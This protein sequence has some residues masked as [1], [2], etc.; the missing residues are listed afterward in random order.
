MATL[1]IETPPVIE[2][3]SL[4]DM[5]RWLREEQDF[6]DNDAQI[7]GLITAARELVEGFTGRSLVTKGYRQCLD[8]FPYYVDTVMSQMAYPPSYYS[9]PRWSTTLWNYSQMI[10]LFVAPLVTVDRIT[11]RSFKDSQWHSLV[12]SVQLWMPGVKYASG[13][14]VRDGNGNLQTAGADG[15][16]GDNPPVWAANLGD[17]TTDNSIPWTNGGASPDDGF[18]MDFDS[19]PP[20]LFP[21]P[22]AGGPTIAFWPSVLYVP[23]AVQIHFTAGY[24]ST[25]AAILASGRQGMV[26][27]IQQLVG[28][29]Y[30]HREAVSPLHM[31]ELPN[32]IKALLWNH[33]IYDLQPTRG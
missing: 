9:L 18:F 20:R 22:A 2:P 5:K 33:K 15:T 19:E 10:K 4:A 12:P 6:T 26:T 11:Y 3:I 25:T 32:H 31:T 16:S 30:E 27:A 17:V 7:S 21:G 23:N 29:W 13:A 1:Q 8:S 24:G 28:E 14:K